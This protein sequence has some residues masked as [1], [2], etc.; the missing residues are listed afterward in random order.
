MFGF[1]HLYLPFRPPASN[2]L[3]SFI[4]TP[5]DIHSGMQACD[6]TTFTDPD[7]DGFALVSNAGA[8]QCVTAI[9]KDRAAAKTKSGVSRDDPDRDGYCH[10][11]SEGDLDVVEW[12]L[13]NHPKPARGE[14]DEEVR[15]GEALF[16]K[17]GCTECHVADWELFSA[18]LNAKDYVERYAGDRRFF[19]LEAQFNEKTERMEGRIV[20]LAEKKDGR[21]IRKRAGY[22]V[23]GFYSDLE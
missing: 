23:G 16:K 5:F 21:W 14:I 20:Y 11:I 17:I 3:R 9:G 7:G 10:E 12:Y 15:A 1:G 19:D 22:R 13:L 6:P 4:A 2:T 8:Q 18:N